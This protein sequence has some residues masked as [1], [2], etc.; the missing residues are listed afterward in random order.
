M[1][2][3]I[4]LFYQSTHRPASTQEGT[5]AE[6]M[7]GVEE[8]GMYEDFIGVTTILRVA[9]TH[10]VVILM[11][12]GCS[13]CLYPLHDSEDSSCLSG[14]VLSHQLLLQCRTPP[15][16]YN[17]LLDYTGDWLVLVLLWSCRTS[18]TKLL[19]TST[20]HYIS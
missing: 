13:S 16:L 12:Y 9:S 3:I 17:T 5:A 20:R 15:S 14:C 7:V 4:V 2:M 6:G 10:V 11:Y 8:E 19:F 18:T 1:T